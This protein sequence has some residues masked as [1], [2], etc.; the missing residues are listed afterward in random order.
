MENPIPQRE[1]ETPRQSKVALQ[2]P[3]YT[4]T[5]PSNIYPKSNTICRKKKK[6]K[7]R[8]SLKHETGRS[9]FVKGLSMGQR[10]SEL[11]GELELR[12]YGEHLRIIERTVK[13]NATGRQ[14]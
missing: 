1:R 9:A 2:F 6:R 7:G 12:S 8:N 5:Q 3:Q 14:Q 4:H 11:K 13:A 10:D